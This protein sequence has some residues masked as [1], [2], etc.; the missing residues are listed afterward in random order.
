VLASSNLEV[1]DLTAILLVGGSTRMP[2][3]ADTL[4]AEFG[5]P[6][7]YAE[8][9]GTVVV[10]GAAH[11]NSTRTDRLL[12]PAAIDDGHIPL[13]W[14]I[15]AHSGMLVRWL[16]EPGARLQHNQPMALVRTADGTLTRLTC[17]TTAGQLV[18]HHADAGDVVIAGQWLATMRVGGPEL[19][20]PS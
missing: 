18:D 4:R 20:P 14:N 8:D 12:A 15:P 13:R 5:L 9:P 11:W 7:R 17:G 16:V 1:G 3:V 10:H 6:I 19:A 2:I